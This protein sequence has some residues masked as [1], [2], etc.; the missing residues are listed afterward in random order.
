MRKM[1][2]TVATVAVAA[3]SARAQAIQAPAGQAYTIANNA[4]ATA[5]TEVTYQWYRNNSPISGA[6]KESYTVP[7]V[8]A[9]G[10]N[11]AFYRMAKAQEC[12]GE[13]EKKSNIV[14]ITF[15]GH[16]AV[17]GCTLVIGGLCWAAANVDNLQTFAAR[18]DMYAKF[19]QWN[20]LTA[21]SA[22]DPLDPAWNATPDNSETWTVNPCPLNWRLPSE[23]EYVRLSGSGSTWENANSVRGNVVNGRFYGYAN[24]T[25]S[26]P[27]NMNDCVFFPAGGWRDHTNGTFSGAGGAGSYWT[28]T[29]Y[30]GA[31]G[32]ELYF[33]KVGS[34]PNG[35]QYKATSLNIR[36]VR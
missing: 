36:C 27:S 24:S 34:Y 32:Y 4:S 26:L 28:S 2:L 35:N 8:Y 22:N 17:E 1:I 3:A 9:Y 31:N 19:Y 12:A 21:Y 29:Q 33:D 10:D 6:T 5:V 14:T 30:S 18:P 16:V 23:E 20:R 13:A 25:C 11:V 15:T 7:A